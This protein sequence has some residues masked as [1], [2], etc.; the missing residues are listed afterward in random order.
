MRG[1]RAAVYKDI[2]LFFSGAGLLSLLLPLLLLPALRWGVGDLSAQSYVRAFPIAVRDLDGTVMSRSLVSQLEQVQLFS[3]VRDLGP[4]E[5]DQDALDAGAAAAITIPRDFFY[6]LYD[7]ADCPVTVTLNGGMELESSLFQAIF[8]SV[9]GIVRADQAAELGLDTFLY[10]PLTTE[11]AY[12]IFDRTAQNLF[13]D[14]LGRQQVFSAEAQA[15]DLAAALQRRLL[16]CVLAVTAMFFALSAVKTL[17][18]EMALGV[19]PRFRAAGGRLGAF[20]LSKLCAAL[21]LTAPVLALAA[22]LFPAADPVALLLLDVLL[23]WAAFGIQTALAAW[24]GSAAAAQRW[25]NILLLVSLA[26]GGTL[27]PRSSLPAPLAW[28]GGLTLPCYAALGLEARAL[29]ADI[30]ALLGWL[31]PLAA[32]GAAGL[33]LAACGFRRRSG[34]RTGAHPARPLAPGAEGAPASPA[35]GFLRRLTD[36]G[37]FKL[38]A[39]SGGIRGLAVTLAVAAL[40]GL[41]AASIRGA[42]PGQLRLAVCDLDSSPLS[43]AL[44]DALDEE[45]GVTVQPL[46]LDTAR[47]ALLA[48]NIEGVLVIENGYAAALEADSGGGLRYEGSGQALS[49]QGA[50]ELAAGKA[51]VQRSTLRAEARAAEALG[52]PLTEAER[53]ALAGAISDADASIPALYVLDTADGAPLADPFV[54]GPMSFAAL[55]ALFT[56]FTAASWC[57]SA[58]SRLAERRLAAFPRG[59]LLAYGSDLAALALLGLLVMLAALLPGGGGALAPA[60]AAY[61][62]TAAA[63]ALALARLAG[64]AGRVDALAPFLALLLCLAGGCFMD[65][66]QLSPVMEAFSL[67]SPAG[68]AVRASEGSAAAAA[69]LVLLTAALGALAMP[70]REK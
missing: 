65:L 24:T 43:G 44:A 9:M 32:M 7:M 1:L 6:E 46:P 21:L 22:A 14:V 47:R 50:R 35:G 27:W 8:Q 4:D 36:L 34:A 20:L 67:L 26:A 28:L 31:W 17:P 33:A 61:A 66:T 29:G 30:L 52:H 16:A 11:R 37:L 63:L 62:L 49:V 39:V 13:Q 45:D 2:K 3:E 25:G 60:A 58:E 70:R 41:T 53:T 40:C 68:L 18:E 48:G 51:A 55:A 57:G 15:S 38:W 19:L 59:R 5:T 23:L 64:P 10:G 42:G 54:P 56:L 69:A 12:A